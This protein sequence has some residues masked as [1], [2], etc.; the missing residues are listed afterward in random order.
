MANAMFIQWQN[1]L[2]ALTAR[3]GGVRV[4]AAL[5]KAD[6]NLALIRDDC[7]A[8]LDQLLAELLT[9]DS[10]NH[11]GSSEDARKETYRIANEIHG[12]AGVF[13]L[14]EL[15]EAAYSLCDLVDRLATLER[16]H[17]PSVD[18]HLAALQLLRRPGSA[19]DS[20]NLLE[21][22]R[23]LVGQIEVISGV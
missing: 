7:V 18:V 3:P 20:A 13:G 23:A 9:L 21:R 8:S 10:P 16:W 19:E 2:T 5:E 22:L 11:P 6:Q 17:Q 4:G 12:M 14:P 1:P 15:G